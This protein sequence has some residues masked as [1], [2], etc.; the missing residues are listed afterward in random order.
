[1]KIEILPKAKIDLINGAS[2]YEKQS[3]NLGKCFLDSMYL[4]IESLYLY[5]GIHIKISSY[6]RLLAKK[7]PY[8]IYYNYDKNYI[9][10]YAVLDCR[11]NPRNIS[12]RLK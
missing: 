10:I 7:F 8:A 6:Y 2:F 12:Q 3:Q 5:K 11:S 1:M 4:E 9:R